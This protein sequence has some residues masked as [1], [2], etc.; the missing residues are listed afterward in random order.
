MKS[1]QRQRKPSVGTRKEDSENSEK[2]THPPKVP[3]PS[4][5]VLAQQQKSVLVLK[6]LTNK[7]SAAFSAIEIM[8]RK[9]NASVENDRQVEIKP[10]VIR[11]TRSTAKT[12]ALSVSIAESFG[13]ANKTK[14]QTTVPSPN[15]QQI[16]NESKERL[17]E[18]QS[19]KSFCQTSEKS[20]KT[21]LESL[22]STS[23]NENND[24]SK[25]C[26]EETLNKEDD[27]EGKIK[28][29][30]TLRQTRAN[31]KVFFS[32]KPAQADQEFESVASSSSLTTDKDKDSTKK[33]TDL[34]KSS[35]PTR[36]TRRGRK[37]Q[38]LSILNCTIQKSPRSKV[39]TEYV[40]S[41]LRSADPTSPSA[42]QVR[43]ST[44][45]KVRSK[46]SKI[47]DKNATLDRWLQVDET[48]SSPVIG[49]KSARLTA[50]SRTL[51][52]S[53]EPMKSPRKSLKLK[54]PPVVETSAME[55]KKVP[56]WKTEPKPEQIHS[57]PEDIYDFEYDASECK[58][59]KKRTRKP[60]TK[61]TDIFKPT[62]VQ[63]VPIRSK[64]VPRAT[65]KSAVVA[66]LKTQ[67]PKSVTPKTKQLVA[68]DVI[69]TTPLLKSVA[70]KLRKLVDS[71]NPDD[72]VSVG[73]TLTDIGHLS[74]IATS[75][76]TFEATVFD[77][78]EPM[79]EP[80]EMEKSLESN[81]L[82]GD[83]ED[84]DETEQTKLSNV[85]RMEPS[86]DNCFGFDDENCVP[87]PAP[88]RSVNQLI[89]STPLK[90]Q[91][92]HAAVASFSV[93]PV[94][95][96]AK[97]TRKSA[98]RPA[99]LDENVARD[100]IRGIQPL[101]QV[102]ENQKQTS[103]LQYIKEVGETENTEPETRQIVP[104]T[105]P[106]AFTQVSFFLKF[107]QNCYFMIIFITA[108]STILL[109]TRVAN[110]QTNNTST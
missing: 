74:P 6:D 89:K 37:L 78:V 27:V 28:N 10:V 52:L 106:S 34:T 21:V 9:K 61:S 50:L 30:K 87:T 44:A 93:S 22:P 102:K 12:T 75:S 31:S 98:N 24:S 33:K 16:H 90:Q 49:R 73:D 35:Q 55:S 95:K 59:K 4:I 79:Q 60:K 48:P 23:L 47:V 25:M 8:G 104:P 82:A 97:A 39:T 29:A 66:E 3:H 17:D 7:T 91:T 71:S 107:L 108:S 40:K 62:K 45:K 1:L 77:S 105:P 70:E 51:N 100:L 96:L 26:S 57:I 83:I 15:K 2:V 68:R 109:E 38:D 63:V 81:V 76:E 5:Y 56:V 64:R 42:R 69:D 85:S 86:V 46:E 80:I 94:K 19:L 53:T 88:T 84:F 32:R 103:L 67:S 13:K 18:V 99:R 92:Q 110:C 41:A 11:Q 72:M 101:K 36:L 43:T 54:S 20:K 58:V 65:L 14:S